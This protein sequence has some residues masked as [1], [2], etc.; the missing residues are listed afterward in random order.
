[1]IPYTKIHLDYSGHKAA[2]DFLKEVWECVSPGYVNY[3][4]TY[5]RDLKVTPYPYF[6]FEVGNPKILQPLESSLGEDN[7]QWSA[8]PSAGWY[9]LSEITAQFEDVGNLINSYDRALEQMK[10]GL[11][12][13][14]AGFDF[15]EHAYLDYFCLMHK[16]SKAI[17]HE[18]RDGRS[19][20]LDSM[21]HWLNDYRIE[22]DRRL[23]AYVRRGGS[24]ESVKNAIKTFPDHDLY[25][26]ANHVITELFQELID[27]VNI[28]K[29]EASSL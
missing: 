20:D 10:V 15:S 14:R 8:I 17:N 24:I 13:R 1:M 29:N 5:A 2:T 27:F 9:E 22:H 23:E 4:V 28:Q 3:H 21:H 16:I 11:E 6:I 18:C 25:S 12:D 19:L 7:C 26:F